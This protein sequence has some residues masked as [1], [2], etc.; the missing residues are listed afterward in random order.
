MTMGTKGKKRSMGAWIDE[1]D[2]LVGQYIRLETT[3][4]IRREGR[5]SG[6]EG[7]KLRIN[8][9]DEKILTEI[10]LNGDPQD[11]VPIDRIETLDV[12]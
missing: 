6:L 9:V 5:L 12:L 11:R 4:G 8:G 2:G 7:R 10:E 3:D 1:L